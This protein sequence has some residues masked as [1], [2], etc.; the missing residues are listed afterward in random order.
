MTLDRG[1]GGQLKILSQEQVY[2]IH[3][4]TLEVLDCVGVRVDHS[5]ALRIMGDNGCKIDLDKKIVKI[6]EYV[7]KKALETCPSRI[8]I[9]GKD[10]K[11]DVV[12]DDT[13]TVHTLGGA[14]ASFVLDLEGQRRSASLQDLVNLTRL[15]DVLPHPHI[16]HLQALPQDIPQIG[17]D[18]IIF[19]TM[20]KNTLK[21]QHTASGGPQGLRDRLE[22]ASVV[23]GSTEEAIKRPFFVENICP[24][25]PLF[26]PYEM[27]EELIEVAKLRVPV[28][29]E[30][31]S[32]AGAT[33]PFTIPGILVEQNANIL[34]AIA[35]IQ[36][37]SSGTPCIYGTAGAIMD[38]RTGNYAGAAPESTLIHLASIQLSHYYHLPFQGG[39]PSDSKLPDAQAGYER[40]LHFLPLFL[41]GCNIIHVATGNLEQ[42]RLTSY[43]QCLIDNEILEAVFRI[44]K[45]IKFDRDSLALRVIEEVGPRGNFLTHPHTLGHLRK[46]RWDPM[47]TNRESWDTWEAKGSKD[48]RER[49]REKIKQILEEHHPRYLSKEMEA[50]IDRIAK[51]SQ[52]Q[53]SEK[54]H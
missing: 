37:I 23:R 41:G 48:M 13:N 47:L 54:L 43:E 5:S 4:A 38:M 19:A 39:N 9:Y 44:G 3:L 30:V 17:A 24:Q 32:M 40:A 49:A 6:P 34:C 50:E 27:V 36:M 21:P 20:L 29:I 25:S 33:A 31:D 42:S 28:I 16:A 18:R 26:H 2:E 52:Q 12:L 7:L 45:G 14:G 53:A 46:D 1:K 11:F 35:L 51:I 22:M 8:T 15:L 10:P